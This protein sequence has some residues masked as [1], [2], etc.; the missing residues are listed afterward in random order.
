ML[1]RYIFSFFL[2]MLTTP[3]FSQN[4]QLLYDL[5][6]TVDPELNPSGNYPILSFEYFKN[7]DTTESGAFMLKVQ[8]D[9]KGE[10]YNIGQTF[11]QLTRSV[12][13]WKPKIYLSFNYSGGLGVTPE[14]YGYHISNSL[15]AGL[16]YTRAKGNAWFSSSLYCRYNAFDKPSIDPQL[17]LYF[18]KGFFYYKLYITG[19]FVFWTQN[20]NQGTEYTRDLSGKKFAF[21]G[22]PQ[23]WYRFYKGISAGSKV[24]VYHHLLTEKNSVQFYPSVGLKFQF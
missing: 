3:V 7:I 12:R 20:R 5:R 8:S 11:I 24:N 13:F 14:Y 19:G 22:D 21:F 16:A 17:S 6:H 2:V 1:M 18:G 4:L 15:A 10:N 23:I 9:L